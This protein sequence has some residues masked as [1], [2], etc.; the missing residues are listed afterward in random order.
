M[1]SET[2]NREIG[3]SHSLKFKQI[4]ALIAVGCFEDARQQLYALPD[5]ISKIR[6]LARTYS[7]MK[8]KSERIP[9]SA[10]E[11]L[12]VINNQSKPRRV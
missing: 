12:N 3:L 2:Q 10:L 1:E 4:S 6:L 8:E 11:E 7:A 9:K 5:S